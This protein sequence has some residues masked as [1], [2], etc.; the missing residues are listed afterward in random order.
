M[1]ANQEHLNILKQGV[2]VWNRWR[3]EHPEI[4]PNLET[5]DLN[6]LDLNLPSASDLQ[7]SRQFRLGVT[8]PHKLSEDVHRGINFSRCVLREVNLSEANL[9]DAHFQVAD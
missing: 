5:I 6:G 9:T 1:V 7:E 8:K 2:V 4:I 3:Q